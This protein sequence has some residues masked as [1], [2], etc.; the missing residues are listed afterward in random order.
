[1]RNIAKF[2]KA[3]EHFIIAYKDGKYRGKLEEVGI[4]IFLVN[5]HEDHPED[6]EADVIH[7]HS[8]GGVS[9]LALNIGHDFPVVET[10]HSPVRSALPAEFVYQRVG[11]SDAVARM[12]HNAITI[13][14]GID[15]DEMD[16]KIDRETIMSRMGWDPSKPVIG[17]LGR[18][19]K[20][21]G[22]EEWILT[23]YYLQQ[24]GFDFTPVI[25]GG[26]ARDCET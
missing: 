17:R 6:F 14:N 22:L 20:D 7:V 9:N 13:K 12:N 2:D 3:N 24:E 18:L 8:G 15:I 10:I 5:E 26:E 19:G 4:K 25:I 11:V 1:M 16:P 21:K 23:C